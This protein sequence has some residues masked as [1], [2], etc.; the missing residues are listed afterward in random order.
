MTRSYKDSEIESVHFVFIIIQGVGIFEAGGVWIKRFVPVQRFF[1][2]DLLFLR[3]LDECLPFQFPRPGKL[4][5]FQAKANSTC[6]VRSR[7]DIR[8]LW[9][10]SSDRG[11]PTET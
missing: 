8:T 7:N 11:F 10:L 5:Q 1:P 6:S 4:S 2:V 3:M 9:K